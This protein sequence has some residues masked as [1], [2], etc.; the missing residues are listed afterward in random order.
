MKQQIKLANELMKVKAMRLL[1]G[2]VTWCL[3]LVLYYFATNLF[4]ETPLTRSMS[5][6][7][8][9]IFTYYYFKRVWNLEIEK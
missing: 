4:W 8:F 3:V 5:W 9:V 2:F 7:V 6:T 1:G